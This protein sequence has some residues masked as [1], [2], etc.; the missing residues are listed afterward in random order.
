MFSNLNKW[1]NYYF[2]IR[3][4][5]DAVI[6]R[7]IYE[8]LN[9]VTPFRFVNFSIIKKSENLMNDIWRIVSYIT[10]SRQ[11]DRYNFIDDLILRI[12][13]KLDHANLERRH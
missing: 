11:Q 2:L 13:K 5:N 4:K 12:K 6:I 10:S 8:K 1:Q 7:Y 9:V 3:I